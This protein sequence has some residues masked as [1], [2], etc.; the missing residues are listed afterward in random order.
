MKRTIKLI[1]LSIFAG[2]LCLASC[3]R[4]LT[5]P[6]QASAAPP[7]FGGTLEIGLLVCLSSECSSHGL[8]SVRGAQLAAEEIN[9]Q[10]GILGKKIDFIGQDTDEAVSGAKAVSAYRQMRN[11]DNIHYIIGPS[12]TPAGLALAPIVSKD[13]GVIMASPSLGAAEF[14]KAGDNL[15]NVRGTD[16]TSSRME[17]RLAY[18]RGARQAA[19]LSSQQ[20]WEKQ[21][22]GFFQDEFERLGGQIVS[23][24]EP[25][26]TVTDV[27][28]EILRIVQ[29]KPEAVFLASM[30]LMGQ[31]G[32]ELT[33]LHYQGLRI[34]SY[35][36]DA[37][38]A[39][40]RGTLEGAI[41]STFQT[42]SAEFRE[43]FH[44][45]YGE[46]PQAEGAIAYDTVYVFARAIE[47]AGTFEPSIVRG[48]ILK[49]EFDGASGHIS[50]DK[51]G[52]AIRR[53]QDYRVAGSKLE[54]L[55]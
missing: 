37:R 8:N 52:C 12:W 43:K 53:I 1:S 23:R 25:L 26:P 42:P 3:L 18:H 33:A 4:N 32:R 17:A 51:Q 31:A 7:Q 54:P 40:A 21:Q 28:S 36:D 11:A 16:E 13:S 2:L 30:I 49:A 45:K 50:F 29:A 14:H 41:F 15:F 20:P 34:G 55:D 27:K 19:I 5:L 39:E 22:A 46:Y 38:L 24:Q 6:F 44:A 47:K 35:I 48:K 10:G 9:A